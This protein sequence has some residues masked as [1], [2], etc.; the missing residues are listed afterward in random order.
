MPPSTKNIATTLKQQVQLLG[1]LLGLMWLSAMLDFYIL[2]GIGYTLA[3]YG[4]IP[5][6]LTGLRGIAFAPFLHANLA[7]LISNS[8]PFLI[9]GGLLM[10]H[11]TRRFLIVTF[12]CMIIGG[13]GTWSIGAPGNHLGA[14]GLIFGYFGFLLL[15]A[16][17]EKSLLSIFLALAAGGLYGGLIWGV[18][19]SQ[20]GV[21]WES[22]L[23][24]FIAGA[25]MAKLVK[26]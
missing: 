12:G 18:L 11:G 24:G 10:L 16:L 6:T 17:Y 21:S 20:P 15:R 23:C 5:R 25:I 13:L 1:G 2:P 8:I 14:S 19:P 22:H 4:I 9:L 7:H 3:D 26:R